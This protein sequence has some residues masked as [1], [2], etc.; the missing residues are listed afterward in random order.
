MVCQKWT[1]GHERE[2]FS[3]EEDEEEERLENFY[4]TYC[5][6]CT[7]R[8]GEGRGG[9]RRTRAAS[10]AS[11]ARCLRKQDRK[12]GT[13]DSTIHVSKIRNKKFPAS[14]NFNGH[15][16]SRSNESVE[17]KVASNQSC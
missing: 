6:S 1:E 7:L 2:T 9:G 17:N 3:V 4:P 11:E 8:N 5:S 13:R 14:S 12:S 16:R 15:G 10:E